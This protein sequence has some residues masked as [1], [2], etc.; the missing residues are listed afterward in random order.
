M[1][2]CFERGSI[3]GDSRY[4]ADFGGE[5]TYKQLLIYSSQLKVLSD[6]PAI[7]YNKLSIIKILSTS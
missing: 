1:Q 2:W 7:T 4:N 3:L 5:D 6:N